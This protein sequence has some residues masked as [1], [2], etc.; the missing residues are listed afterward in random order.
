MSGSFYLPVD[1]DIC[2]HTIIISCDGRE[3]GLEC[4]QSSDGRESF[5]SARESGYFC[6][7]VKKSED[8]VSKREL[9]DLPPEAEII[10]TRNMTLL[11]ASFIGILQF[12]RCCC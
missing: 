2:A 9:G 6:S 5:T 1:N 7:I 12:S 3:V 11:A 10:L 4:R 8:R